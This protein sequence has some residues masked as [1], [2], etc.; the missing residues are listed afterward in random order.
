MDALSQPVLVLAPMTS[1]L[2]PLVRALGA[3]R[4]RTAGSH[5]VTVHVAADQGRSIVAARLGVGPAVARNR[6]RTL[7]EAVSPDHVVVSGICGSLDPS[8]AIGALVVPEEVIDL[9]SDAV[10]R[11]AAPSGFSA[12]GILATTADLISD[13]LQLQAL[14]ARGVTALD[15]ETAAVAAEC[16][17]RGCSWSVFRAVSDTPSQTVVLDSA[18]QL[19]KPDGSINIA[20]ALRYMLSHPQRVPDLA[21]FGRNSSRAARIAA[22]AALR[23]CGWRSS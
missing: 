17:A 15:M 10:H 14:V 20:A 12:S 19:L 4:T 1:E 9:E 16:E 3:Q 21:R 8:L 18:F 2:Q 11:P 22:H 5:G 13:E 7:L 6:T 23:S